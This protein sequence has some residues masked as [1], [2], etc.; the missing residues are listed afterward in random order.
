MRTELDPVKAH[1]E[2]ALALVHT[3]ELPRDVLQKVVPGF[4]RSALEASF[5]QTIRRKRLAAGK[6]HDDIE[7][8]LEGANKLTPLAA[9]ALFDDK[10]RG[11]D[12][13]RRLNQYGGWAGDTFKQCN[14]GA[15]GAATA[16][17]KQLVENTESLCERVLELK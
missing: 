16:D 8:E 17:L 5:M 7:Q 3:T 12:V 13:M 2:D 11:G 1:I 6:A 14:E 15:H 10:Q 4:C 9:L